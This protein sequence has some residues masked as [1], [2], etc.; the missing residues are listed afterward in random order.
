MHILYTSRKNSINNKSLFSKTTLTVCFSFFFLLFSAISVNQAFGIKLTK[1]KHLFDITHN[2]SQPSDVSVSADGLIYIV[3]GV[4]NKI[5]VFDQN[6]KFKFSFGEKGGAGAQLM[7][8]L[9]IDVDR[10]SGR[11]YV[12]DTGNHRVQVFSAT[13]EYISQV[14][15]PENEAMPSD[16]TDVAVDSSINRLFVV[17][18]DNHY[19]LVYDLSTLKLIDTFG[20]PGAE[21]R[22]F[23]YPFLAALDKEK[24]IYISDV[25]NTR[26]Q[27]FNSDG[28]FVTVIGGWGVEKGRFFRPKGIAIDRNNLVYVTDSYMGVIQLFKASGEFHSVI[29]EQDG[30]VKKFIKPMGIFIDDN[31][32]LYVVE[33]F[34][35]RVRVYDIEK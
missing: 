31:N 16:P 18:N 1:V 30:T 3:D 6:G 32:R 14:E 23:R 10:A 19:I 25:V 9:G 7:F 15:I 12:A 2:F 24:Y 13:G 29:G 8:P 28:Q 5:K 21:K 20:V 26:V 11:V 22:E 35:D 34:A 4:N 27:V 33:M 17:D